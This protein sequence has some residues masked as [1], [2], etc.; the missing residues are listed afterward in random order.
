MIE[1]HDFRVLI[2]YPNLSMMLTPSY[3]VALFTTIL[4]NQGYQIDLFD[5][6]PYLP[7]Y[8]FLAEPLPVTRANKLLNSR[9]FDPI[10][11][12]GDPK[13]DLEGDF[14][15]KLD[16]FKPHVVIFSTLVEDT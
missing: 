11:L 1:K 6:T 12:W 8:E 13:T 10:S 16:E 2:A 4:R 9:K 15:K 14:A 3:A 5:C 7:K